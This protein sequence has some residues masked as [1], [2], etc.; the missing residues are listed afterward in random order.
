[1]LGAAVPS[2]SHSALSPLLQ[3]VTELHGENHDTFSVLHFSLLT[4]NGEKTE[5][6][7]HFSWSIS[8]SPVEFFSLQDK[9]VVTRLENPTLGG[10]GACSVD[11]VASHHAHGDACSLALVDCIRY[12]RSHWVL[13]PQHAETGQVVYYVVF[14]IPVRLIFKVYLRSAMEQS[15][16]LE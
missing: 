2:S 12:F 1:M 5:N 13:N 4:N 6:V 15:Q 14:V 11:V 9:A 7:T 3:R 16:K 8:D 10:N